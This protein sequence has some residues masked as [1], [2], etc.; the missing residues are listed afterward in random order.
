MRLIDADELLENIDNERA[1][2]INKRSGDN[3]SKR[4]L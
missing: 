2:L 1:Y 4:I 3:V